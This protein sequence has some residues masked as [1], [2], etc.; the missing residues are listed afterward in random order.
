MTITRASS[1]RSSRRT[2]DRP[3]R[4]RRASAASSPTAPAR[5]PTAATLEAQRAR[6]LPIYFYDWDQTEPTGRVS[7]VPLYA[8]IDDFLG[9]ERI[10]M[11]AFPA[12]LRL[13]RPS[14]D[15]YLLSLP[16]HPPR[17]SA[18]ERL[19]S[20]AVPAPRSPGATRRA[21]GRRD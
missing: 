13:K 11:M 16:D 12:Y 17:R 19:S 14:L 2:G 6:L 18:R 3:S 15:R 7:V 4:S 1:V 8:D 5:A 10:E 20:L 21:R 9:Y